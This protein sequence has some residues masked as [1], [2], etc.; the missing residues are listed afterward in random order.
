MQSLVWSAKICLSSTV[1]GKKFNM[2]PYVTSSIRSSR[3]IVLRA[4]LYSTRH[5]VLVR[6]DGLLHPCTKARPT[7]TL[8][9][10]RTQH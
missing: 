8:L 10:G 5:L 4:F 2:S 6:E 7:D 3:H 1:E 9:V